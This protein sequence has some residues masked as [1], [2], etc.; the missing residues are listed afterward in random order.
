MLKSGIDQDALIEMFS[1]ASAR[2]SQQLRDAVRQ[3]TLGALQG[4][5]LT[6]KNIRGVLQKVSEAA[7]TGLA[8]T[9]TCR[10]CSTTPSP[11]WTTRC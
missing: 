7:T 11:A 5:E 2:Q 1:S 10:P 6:L 8:K 3:A 9:W 4:R